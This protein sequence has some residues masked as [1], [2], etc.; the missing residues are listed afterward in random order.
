MAKVEKLSVT[1]SKD[2]LAWARRRA[3]AQGVSLSAVLSEALGWRRRQDAWD[4][5]LKQ[6][7]AE[8]F[9]DA[10]LEAARREL[11]GLSPAEQAG[12]K[13]R[14]RKAGYPAR[15]DPRHRSDGCARAP[16]SQGIF[17]SEPLKENPAMTTTSA[18]SGI[19]G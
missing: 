11:D 12:G 5:W 6:A 1:L 18:A 15:P 8:P 16:R 14:R 13:P 9:N 10:E 19:K 3:K 7:I 2:D 4:A 17:G